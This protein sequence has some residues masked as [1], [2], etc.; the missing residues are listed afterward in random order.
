MARKTL[1]AQGAAERRKRDSQIR[2]AQGGTNRSTKTHKQNRKSGDTM[3]AAHQADQSEA[4]FKRAT[5]AKSAKSSVGKNLRAAAK[6][7]MAKK[8]KKKNTKKR[9]A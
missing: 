6:K 4:A 8:K 3:T 1:A 7:A 5:K 2:S 9:Y